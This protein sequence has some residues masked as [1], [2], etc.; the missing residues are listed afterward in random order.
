MPR[1]RSRWPVRRRC[2]PPPRANRYERGGDGSCASAHRPTPPAFADVPGPHP[3]PSP[4]S[5]GRE[6]TN[7]RPALHGDGANDPP[8]LRLKTYGAIGIISPIDFLN[9]LGLKKA[10]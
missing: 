7:S 1:S 8:I 5:Q 2:A 9:T 6:L 10:A 3:Y 4:A